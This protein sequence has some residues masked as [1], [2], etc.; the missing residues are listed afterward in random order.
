MKKL[1]YALFYFLSLLSLLDCGQK[2]EHRQTLKKRKTNY[3]A[4][5]RREFPR[6]GL[7]LELA[8]TR[9][10]Y[11]INEDIE[12]S[13]AIQNYDQL[14][15]GIFPVFAPEGQ[16]PANHP[17]VELSLHIT[18]EAGTEIP[19]SGQ[20]EGLREPPPL[21]AIFPLAGSCFYGQRVSLKKGEFAYAI[22]NPGVYRIRAR[23]RHFAQQW[24]KQRLVSEPYAANHIIYEASRVFDGTLESNEVIFKV[25][26]KGDVN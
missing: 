22:T 6:E 26:D 3:V 21:Q 1:H 12:V 9:N 11:N 23:L 4:T 25:I 7:N 17:D 18:D 20:Y 24:V 5:E 8:M 13:V 16:S 19:Y 14:Y 10:V 2:E 15:W